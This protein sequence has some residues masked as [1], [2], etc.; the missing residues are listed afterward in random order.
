VSYL[1]FVVIVIAIAFVLGSVVGS[2]LNVCIARIPLGESV[3]RPS[4]R[5]PKCLSPILW[6]QN[7]PLFS[8]VFLRGRCARCGQAI[9]IRYPFVELLSGLLFVTIVWRFGIGWTT[10]YY[11]IF[12][13]MLI[14]ATFIDFD[15]QIIPNAITLPGIIIGF[16]GSFVVPWLGWLD[17]L[18]GVLLGG[19]SLW[20]VAILYFAMTKTE[21][22]GMGDVK[23]LGMIGAFLG[24]HK[25]LLVVLLSS[26]VGASIGIIV[27]MI[28]GKDR[29]LAIPFGPYLAFGAIISLIWGDA[30]I[31]WYFS[32]F[33]L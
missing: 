21:G 13:A 7:V 11:W 22:M 32:Y 5:C 19:G 30:L 31:S 6:F 17:S 18:L 33:S 10:C 26:M 16:A 14:V 27:M 2:F 1:Q 3:V 23:M 25:I 24:A 9:S 29:K 15:H 28:G 20:L 12:V 4:S 8:Y